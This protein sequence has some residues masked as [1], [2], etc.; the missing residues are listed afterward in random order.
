MRGFEKMKKILTI[1]ITFFVVPFVALAADYDID[2][3]Y[4]D[5]TIKNNG[6]MDVSELIVL[7]GTFNGYERDILY[8]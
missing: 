1:I 8:K 3:F 5:A 4:I 6:D 2:H 7:N